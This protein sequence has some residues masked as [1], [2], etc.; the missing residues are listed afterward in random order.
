V[1]LALLYCSC[2][3]FLYFKSACGS[4]WLSVKLFGIMNFR[5][6]IVVLVRRRALLGTHVL[7]ETLHDIESDDYDFISNETSVCN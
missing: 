6:S 2:A 5:A 7:I 3:Q 1:E 4:I